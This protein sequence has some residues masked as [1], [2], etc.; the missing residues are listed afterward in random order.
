MGGTNFFKTLYKKDL[1]C[2]NSEDLSTMLGPNNK[3]FPGFHPWT[4]LDSL[5]TR[6]TRIIFSKV[7]FSAVFMELDNI[8][9]KTEVFQDLFS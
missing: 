6:F 9:Q 1:D 7:G 4:P 3:S 2:A 5:N 8:K